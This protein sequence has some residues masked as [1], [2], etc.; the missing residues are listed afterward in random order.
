MTKPKPKTSLN[1]CPFCGSNSSQFLES[2][3]GVAEVGCAS[4]S[5]GA[6]VGIPVTHQ[7][8]EEEALSEARRRW[9]RRVK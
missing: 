3:Y 8:S 9:N 1:P 4:E 2:E 5:C 7:T 6:S